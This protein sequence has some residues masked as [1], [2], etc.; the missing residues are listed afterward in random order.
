[1]RVGQRQP[2]ALRLLQYGVSARLKSVGT[3][4]ATSSVAIS[5]TAIAT[6]VPATIYATAIS[7]PAQTDGL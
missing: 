7:T 4:M 1:M 2:N 3:A 5:V 6:S